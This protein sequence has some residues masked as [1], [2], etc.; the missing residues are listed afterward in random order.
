VGVTV[1]LVDA[2]VD[3]GAILYRE[4]IEV[5]DCS[6]LEAMRKKLSTMQHRI[7][8]KCTRRLIENQIVPEPQPPS[9][10]KQYYVMH[11]KLKKVVAKRLSQGYRWLNPY[12]NQSNFS[13]PSDRGQ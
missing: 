6:T 13:N 2:G 7:L 4:E 8:A 10:G 11:A 9:E 3:T 1:H 12:F 5:S